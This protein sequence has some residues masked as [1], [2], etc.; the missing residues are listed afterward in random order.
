MFVI[1]TYVLFARYEA[2]T[3]ELPMVQ[4][5]RGVRL[6]AVP[7]VSKGS[8][9]FKSNALFWVIQQRVVVNFLPSLFAA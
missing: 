6:Y 4:V 7:G 5:L 2:L 1:M 3:P 8:I 9:A